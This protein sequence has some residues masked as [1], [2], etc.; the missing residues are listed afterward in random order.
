MKCKTVK[1]YSISFRHQV[2]DD[3]E[4]GRFDSIESARIHY[5]IGGIGTVQRWLR[6][7]GK[8]HLLP[9]VVIVQ[10]PNEKDQICELRQK[11]AKLEQAL[12]QTQVENLLNAAFLDMACK[13]LDCDVD[14]FKKKV[15]TEQ[16]TK[17]KGS[18]K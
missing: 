17:S 1:R 4:S 14:T 5:C 6:K 10:K 11:I 16:F 3:L 18:Q 8:N 2:V 7:Y 13:E 9:K 15:D 12:G